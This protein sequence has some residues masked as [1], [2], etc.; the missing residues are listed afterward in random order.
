MRVWGGGK[1]C[2]MR[3][4]SELVYDS[5]HGA[6]QYSYNAAGYSAVGAVKMRRVLL[7]TASWRIG[8]LPCVRVSYSTYGVR[9]S[10]GLPEAHVA[11]RR[12]SSQRIYCTYILYK[13]T[14][15]LKRDGRV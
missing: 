13:N 5:R 8:T 12:C 14:L 2:V 10:C 9:R 11:R 15:D 4:D 1:T 3:R 6:V 7:V